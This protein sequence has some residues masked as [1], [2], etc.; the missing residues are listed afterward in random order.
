MGSRRA[1]EIHIGLPD[2]VQTGARIGW[3][4]VAPADHRL[5]EQ[6]EALQCDGRQQV[7]A[8]GEVVVRGAGRHAGLGGQRAQAQGFE[9]LP[10]DHVDTDVDQGLLQ[11]PVVVAALFLDSH[12]VP[13]VPPVAPVA[14]EKMNRAR[15]YLDLFAWVQ[16]EAK[17]AP[18]VAQPIAATIWIDW[19]QAGLVK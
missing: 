10:V 1:G 2:G 3:R 4:G 8:V 18:E 6:L 12:R 15:Q 16:T 5:P 13:S 9:A 14:Q 17:V 11:I 19:K 7:V